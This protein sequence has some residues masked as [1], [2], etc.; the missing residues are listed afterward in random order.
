MRTCEHCKSPAEKEWKYCGMC[1]KQLLTS[2]KRQQ[3]LFAL[4]PE[5]QEKIHHEYIY[6][7]NIVDYKLS[8]GIV[9][10]ATVKEIVSELGKPD[11]V[12]IETFNESGDWCILKVSPRKLSKLQSI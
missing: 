3:E 1:G 7:D 2:P 6:A 8:N 4:N 11:H 9:V 12:L 5:Q 10:I